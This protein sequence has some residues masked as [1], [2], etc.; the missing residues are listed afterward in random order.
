MATVHLGRLLGPVGFSRTVAIKR[1]HA[2]F[3]SD[4]EFVSMFLDEARL[5]ARIRHPNVVPTLDVV[6]TGGEL[7]L[8]MEYV[9]GESAARLS[10]ALRERQTTIPLRI[11]SGVMTGVL[12]GL[13]SAHEAKDERGHPLGIVHRDV[14]PQ[15]VLVGTDG[16]ARVL[17]FGVAK[18]A[19]R[20]QTT[21]EGQIKGKLSYMPPE[22][23]R[24]AS[25]SRQ[26]DIYACG[27]MLWELV[28]GQR[29]FAGDNE[30]AIVAKVLDGRVDPPS[31]V[32]GA[33]KKTLT[34]GMMRQ[35]EALDSTILRALH[36]QQE[37]RFTTAREMALEIER[38]CPPATASEIGDWVE[39]VARDV[40]NSRA[41]MIAEIESSA[42]I[43][44]SSARESKNVMSLLSGHSQPPIAHEPQVNMTAVTRTAPSSSSSR[45]VAT[46]DGPPVTQP[47]SISVSTATPR[48]PGGSR[49]ALAAF[50]GVLVGVLLLAGGVVGVKYLRQPTAAGV[51]DPALSAAAP[52]TASGS[53]ASDTPDAAVGQADPPPTQPPVEPTSKPTAT[54]TAVSQKP[55]AGKPPK[56][57]QVIPKTIQ[58]VTQPPPSGDDCNPP[59]WYDAQG[60]KHYKPNCL[61]K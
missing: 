50:I 4:P 45:Y 25:V 54:A 26:T 19:G 58:T 42:S 61:G 44:P 41:Q 31:R 29:L 22:Q 36:M 3:A 1:L 53:V 27:V 21:K 39:S 49:R 7:F 20:M 12:H 16:V 2:Q 23:L 52:G 30:G 57:Q 6:A 34:D 47:S 59:Y 48:D 17:D 15:N 8:V 37:M 9:P 33:G 28:T 18:A 14:S 40:L 13:H 32:I 56:Q 35:I 24:G 5:A 10:R 11:L 46:M 51:V 55:P 38:K 60:V 43:A